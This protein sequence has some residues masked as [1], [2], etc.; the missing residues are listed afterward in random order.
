MKHYWRI[1]VPGCEGYSFAVITEQTDPEYVID[2]ARMEGLFE[3]DGDANYATAE[4]ITDDD[5]EMGFWEA[6]AIE[7]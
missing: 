4:D 1:D 3:L 5:Y 7:L 6:Q 2:D